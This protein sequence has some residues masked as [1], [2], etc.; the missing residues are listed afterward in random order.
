MIADDAGDYNASRRSESVQGITLST[1]LAAS[2]RHKNFRGIAAYYT[3]SVSDAS[4]SCSLTAMIEMCGSFL[5]MSDASK[6][7][8]TEPRFSTVDAAQKC[9]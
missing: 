4:N 6:T 2:R 9:P 7:R 1:C 5:L 8:Q 3:M